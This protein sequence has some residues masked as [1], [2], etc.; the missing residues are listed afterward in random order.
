MSIKSVLKYGI[1]NN[2]FLALLYEKIYMKY[3]LWKRRKITVRD[4]GQHNELDVSMYTY[5]NDFI[6]IF[7]GN[8]NT[9]KVGDHCTFKMTNKIYI[10][11][12]NNVV[13]IG[14]NVTFDQDVLIVAAEGTK[15]IIGS[16]C[17]FAYH[18]H[19]R[20][21]DQHCIFNENGERINPAKDIQIGNHV[22]LG[23]EFVIMKGVRIGDGAIVGMGAMVTKDVPERC[24][25]VG[26]PAKVI[27]TDVYW[28]E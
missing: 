20:T 19:I 11:G 25:V 22:W 13:E 24:I 12:D 4:Y 23:R 10:Q 27:K 14:D 8:N 1:V 5:S 6:V 28:H 2:R 26:K 9:V 21:S 3:V 17:I 15:V 18:V 7:H 16:D